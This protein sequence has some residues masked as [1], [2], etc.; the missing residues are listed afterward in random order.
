MSLARAEGRQHVTQ[1]LLGLEV[2]RTPDE[3]LSG[4]FAAG[5]PVF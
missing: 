3:V 2:R 1:A 4:G 5:L